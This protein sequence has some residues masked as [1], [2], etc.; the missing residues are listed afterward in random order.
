MGAAIVVLAVPGYCC[1]LTAE[2]LLKKSRPLRPCNGGS[3][4]L[5]YKLLP[6]PVKLQKQPSSERLQERG[7]V[8]SLKTECG[9]ILQR[10]YAPMRFQLLCQRRHDGSIWR[11][12]LKAH[13]RN[14]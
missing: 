6:A 10:H 14:F 5:G 9:T 13:C 4:S 3:A 2:E 8:C 12:N 1:A 7:G 11:K